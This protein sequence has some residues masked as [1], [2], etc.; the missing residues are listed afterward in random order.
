VLVWMLAVE[1][2]LV[3][4]YPSV[5]KWMPWGVSN[6]LLQLGPELD[7]EGKLLSVPAAGLLL[8]AY[9]AAAGLLALLMTP[10]RDV[11]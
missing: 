9:T 3:T 6:A 11:L 2:I 4:S 10:K 7:L 5:G 8:F 1:Q